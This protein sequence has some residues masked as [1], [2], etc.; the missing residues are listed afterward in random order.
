MSSQPGI[1]SRRAGIGVPRQG[2]SV[3]GQGRG[4]WPRFC[5]GGGAKSIGAVVWCTVIVKCL[6][7]QHIKRHELRCFALLLYGSK[8]TYLVPEGMVNQTA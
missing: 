3:A 7:V 1:G 4:S 6:K 5:V 2:I 8:E